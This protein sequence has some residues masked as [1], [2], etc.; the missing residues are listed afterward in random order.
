L[1]KALEYCDLIAL[2]RGEGLFLLGDVIGKG[3]AASMLMAQLHAIFRSLA[4]INRAVTQLVSTPTEF[5]VR[6]R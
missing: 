1:A 2:G 5:P 6:A 3:V 4:P